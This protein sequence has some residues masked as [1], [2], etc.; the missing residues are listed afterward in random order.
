MRKLITLLLAAL[1]LVACEQPVAT[2][3]VPASEPIPVEP[4]SD[5]INLRVYNSAWQ[6][7]EEAYVTQS[8]ALTSSALIEAYVDEYN[9]THTDDQLHVVYGE[10]AIPLESA[11]LADAYIIRS[12]NTVSSEYHDVPRSDLVDRREVWR[13]QAYAEAGTLYVD[14]IPPAPEPEPVITD[15]ERYALYY[16]LVS[17]GSIL[18]E[19]HCEDWEVAGYPSRQACYDTTRTSW[20]AQVYA[21]GGAT[22]LVAGRLYP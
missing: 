11:P 17:D 5:P 21:D 1:A 14:R 9:E 16:V 18:A 2:T 22:E 10:T 3:P 15:Y 8:R 4:V 19:T 6:I 13:A 12:D 20:Q 7:V